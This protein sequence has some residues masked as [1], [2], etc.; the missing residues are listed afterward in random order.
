MIPPRIIRSTSPIATIAWTTGTA[1]GTMQGSCRPL[2]ERLA[3]S[4]RDTSTVFCALAMEDGGLKATLRRSGMPVDI[5]PRT[6]P[7]L[8]VRV[9][10]LPSL[11]SYSSLFSDPLSLE[12]W[13]PAPNSTPLA[14]GIPNSIFASSESRASKSGSPTPTGRF[15]AV[16]STTPPTLSS[17]EEHTSELQ[18][19]RHLLCRL[20]LQKKNQ[21]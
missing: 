9:V 3:S 20:H 16:H 12:D 19:L 21:A 13:K 2:T 8:L 7:E 4:I 18:S 15:S 6:P 17:S 11:I 14:A 1:F 10:I 5:P